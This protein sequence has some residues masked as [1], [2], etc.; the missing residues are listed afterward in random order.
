MAALNLPQAPE[1]YD[2]N[3]QDRV[4]GAIM[5]AISMSVAGPLMLPGMNFLGYVAR[6]GPPTLDAVPNTGDFAFYG[7]LDNGR[8]YVVGNASGVFHW[9]A[10]NTGPVP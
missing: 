7:N 10:F 2:K 3:E 8:L 4:R 9:I 5:R 1:R 6:N